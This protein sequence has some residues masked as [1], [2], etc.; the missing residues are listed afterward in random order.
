M[1]IYI[2]IVSDNFTLLKFWYGFK[3][4]KVFHSS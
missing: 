2:N 3:S 1:E 4:N